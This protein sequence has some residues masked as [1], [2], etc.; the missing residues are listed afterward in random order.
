MNLFQEIETEKRNDEIENVSEQPCT[1]ML[2]FSVAEREAF[3]KLLKGAIKTEYGDQA[4]DQNISD[5]LM[6]LLKE[7]YGTS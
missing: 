2:H 4:K 3:Y 5:F 6:K 7:Q 1:V